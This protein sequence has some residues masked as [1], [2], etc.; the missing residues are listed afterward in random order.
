[1]LAV[2]DRALGAAGPDSPGVAYCDLE[3]GVP[4]WLSSSIRAMAVDS[5]LIAPRWGPGIMPRPVP[6]VERAAVALR[7]AGA[8]IVVGISGHS[9]YG[10]S[11]GI[12]YDIGD[13]V[14]RTAVDPEALNDVGLLFLVTLDGH[15]PVEVEAVP[16][17]LDHGHTR[18]AKP[19]E[20]AWI[21]R[22]FRAA[23]ASLGSTVDQRDGRL[24]LRWNPHV[25]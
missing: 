7:A 18:L 5:V 6:H 21:Y 14:R 8:D 25:A 1:M 3:D 10:A 15:A 24:L 16:L 13:L 22:H 11:E 20:T 4:D 17:A 23:C 9:V 12:L 2:T 19:A